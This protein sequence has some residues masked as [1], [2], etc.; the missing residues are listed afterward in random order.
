MWKALEKLSNEERG[1][2]MRFW[3]GAD[4]VAAE[5]AKVMGLKISPTRRGPNFNAGTCFK[6]L[7]V[8][9]CQTQEKM[10]EAVKIALANNGK[11]AIEH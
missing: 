9:I 7:H 6:S 8:P 11:A 4:K 3:T 10:D 2:F 1:N 5:G